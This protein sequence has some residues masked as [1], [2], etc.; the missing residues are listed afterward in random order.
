M[1]CKYFNGY[2][3]FFTINK[4]KKTVFSQISKRV[5]GC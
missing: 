3:S 1:L 4:K 2:T 5:N